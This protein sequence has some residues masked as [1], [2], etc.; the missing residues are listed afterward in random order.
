MLLGASLF[1][2]AALLALVVLLG[3]LLLARSG[4]FGPLGSSPQA[5]PAVSTSNAATGSPSASASPTSGSSTSGWL[6]VSP[7]TVRL[8]CSSGQQTQFVVLANQ[9]PE[10]VQWQADLPSSEDQAGVTLS[11]DHGQLRAGASIVLQLRNKSQNTDHQGVI[12]FDATGQD[13]GQ[14]PSLSYTTTACD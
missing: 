14:S 5:S 13:A 2:N 7:T 1:A 10:Q 11:P 4:F 12:R 9:G 3:L 8:G 6:Q